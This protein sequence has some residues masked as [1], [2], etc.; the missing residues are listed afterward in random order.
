MNHCTDGHRQL[1]VGAVAFTTTIDVF[2]IASGGAIVDFGDLSDT[3]G[4]FDT[5]ASDGSRGFCGQG[6]Y[7]SVLNQQEYINIGV[8]GNAIDFSEAV[9]ATYMAMATSGG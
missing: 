5:G 6:N 3:A 9:S 8:Y 4:D 2:V 1:R 7:G